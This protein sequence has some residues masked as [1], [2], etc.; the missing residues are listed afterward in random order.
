MDYLY[1][2]LIT[3]LKKKNYSLLLSNLFVIIFNLTSTHYIFFFFCFFFNLLH[4][5]YG[6]QNFK[7]AFDM[8]EP[9]RFVSTHQAHTFQLQFQL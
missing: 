9:I 4:I 3:F 2:Y 7:S 8:Q 5:K 6:K 1:F